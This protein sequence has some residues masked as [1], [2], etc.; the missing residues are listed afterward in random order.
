MRVVEKIYS[1]SLMYIYKYT[2]NYRA[3]LA[4][5]IRMQHRIMVVVM[6]WKLSKSWKYTCKDN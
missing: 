2:Y 5:S 6:K 3:V 1:Y 4:K